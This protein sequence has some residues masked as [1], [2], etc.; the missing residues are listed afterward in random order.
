MADRR[1]P[2]R[3]TAASGH[4]GPRQCRWAEA[5]SWSDA[6]LALRYQSVFETATDGI[7][8]ITEAGTI[9]S[10]NAAVERLFGLS[11]D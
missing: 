6:E 10:A 8:V 2:P 9:E 3:E 4:Q 7:I 11:R 5:A 1:K